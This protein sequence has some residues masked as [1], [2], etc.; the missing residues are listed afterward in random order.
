MRSLGW[1]RAPG[2]GV[3]LEDIWAQTP[4]GGCEEAGGRA[5]RPVI[6]TSAPELALVRLCSACTAPGC[7]VSC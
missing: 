7:V 6:C 4:G 1:A 3:L 5:L 2:P